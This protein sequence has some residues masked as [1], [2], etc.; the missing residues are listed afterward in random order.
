MTT[1]APSQTQKQS[2]GRQGPPTRAWWKEASIYQIYPASFVDSNGDGLGDIRG[3]ISKLDYLHS[4]GVDAVWLCPI[5]ESPQK[6]MGYDIANYRAI[7]AP[8]GTLEDVEELTGAL[9]ARGMKMVMDLV[10]NHSSDQ[11]AW[12]RESRSSKG[13]PKHDWYIWRAPRFV[14]GKRLPPNN[15]ASCFGGS[16]WAYEEARGEY[17]LALFCPEQPD[18]NWENPDVVREVHDIMTFWLEKGV[19]GFRMDV[20][21]MIS[22]TPGFPDAAVSLPGREWQP[23]FEHHSYGPRLN[24]FL[25]GLREV[26]DRY[27]AFAV[28][29]MPCVN[30]DS[31]VAA[32]VAAERKELNMIF[33]FDIVDMDIGDDGKFSPRKWDANTLKNIVNR[34]QTFM[35]DVDGWNALFLENHD[36]ARSVSRFTKHRPEHRTLAAKMLATFI[37]TQAGTLYIY[38]GQEL[39]MTSL[40]ETWSM[41]QFKD[42]ES[43][44]LHAEAVERFKDNKEAMEIFMRDLRKKARDNARS[45]MQ[46]NGEKNAGFSVAKPWMRVNDNY[47]EINAQ[48]QHGEGGSVLSY[49]RKLLQA[50]K[51]YRDS[52]VYGNFELVQDGHEAVICFKR[53]GGYCADA[54]VVVNFT[55]SEQSWRPPAE[56]RAMIA[57]GKQV[58]G[59]YDDD[60]VLEGDVLQLRP[61]ESRVLIAQGAV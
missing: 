57:S 6:D 52:L 56:L 13:N 53:G 48:Q 18:L 29:E 20:I 2:P 46:W 27:D 55:D 54:W 8:Y 61:F 11:H 31:Q 10:V 24:E 41:D 37:G 50:R 34:W 21:N 19:D 4:L 3:V 17:Y 43:L 60:V 7:H 49:W 38:Q 5:Y 26:L 15:W 35:Y 1:T 16:A 39:G 32:V 12:F 25:K 30:Q 23:A 9:H 28:G 45:P 40:P 22:K 42:I 58:L 33:Q 36:Q 59:N 51:D 14:D 44:N 47:P